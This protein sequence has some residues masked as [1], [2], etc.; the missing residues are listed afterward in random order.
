VCALLASLNA[1]G[2]VACTPGFYAPQFFQWLE[3]YGPTWYTSAPTIHQAVLARVEQN[4]RI[5]ERCHLRLIRSSAASLP[6]SVIIELERA[7]GVPVIESY[8]MTEAAVQ[9]TTNPLPP[10][11]R[12][13]GS[14]GVAWGSDVAI[15]GADGKLL[16]A[17]EVGEV[18]IRGA[19]VIR[20]YDAD[21]EINSQAFVD[22]WLRTGD[23]GRIDEDGYL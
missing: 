22:G 20:A 12:K 2:S 21:A 19:N 7:F 6:P 11:Q 14:V 8:G 17:N 10:R 18:I 9:I 15:M 23:Q 4:R 3:E 13:I 1:G 5:I 16:K